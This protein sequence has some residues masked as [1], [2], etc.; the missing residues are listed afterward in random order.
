MLDPDVLD[1][2]VP[3]LRGG[4]YYMKPVDLLLRRPSSGYGQA[5]LTTGFRTVADRAP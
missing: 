4:N 1:K 3:V 2:Q 5:D